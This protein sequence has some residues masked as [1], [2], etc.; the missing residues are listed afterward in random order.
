MRKLP[1]LLLGFVLLSLACQTLMS[2]PPA[3]TTSPAQPETVMATAEAET[4]SV[5]PTETLLPT[6]TPFPTVEPITCT[7]DACL[8]ACLQRIES[9]VPKTEYEPLTGAYAEHEIF[10]NLVYYDVKDGQLGKPQFLHVPDDFMAY[11][12]DAAAHQA[13]WKYASSLLSLE[14][15]RWINQFEIFSSTHYSGWVKPAGRDQEDRSHWILGMELTYAQDPVEATYTLVHEYG[16][17]LTLNTDQIPASDY[18]YGWYQNPAVCKQFLSPDGCSRPDS[19]INQFYD[20][21][22]TG[23]FDEWLTDVGRPVVNSSEE[24]HTLVEDFYNKHSEL[25]VRDYAATNIYEDMAESFMQ[26]VLSPRPTGV[27]VVE[28]KILFFYDFPEL[29]SLRQQ[30][31]QDICSYTGQ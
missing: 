18:Y 29:V 12:Q 3:A 31:I 8:D 14:Q 2:T 25:F 9:A 1:L 20:R 28:K 13:L 5:T 24:L 27:S 19:Y 26:F 6:G 16:H 11:Q 4:P 22:W 17:M 23:I 10:L 30:M 15:L 21:F 7:D